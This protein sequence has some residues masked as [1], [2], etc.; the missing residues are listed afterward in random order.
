MAS[1]EQP[2]TRADLR[3]EIRLLRNDLR[4][5]Y[6]TKA[7]LEA[8]KASLSKDL[9]VHFRWIVGTYLATIAAVVVALI[10]KS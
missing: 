5:H 7:D 2:V 6:A 4:D 3:E 10:Q 9:N 1:Q 8:L